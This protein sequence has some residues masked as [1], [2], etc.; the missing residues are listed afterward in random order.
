MTKTIQFK[1][2]QEEFR[3]L[4]ENAAKNKNKYIITLKDAPKNASSAILMSN[5]EYE[6][7]QETLEIMSDKKLMREIRE[8]EKEIAEGK[9]E[10]WED[11]KKELG[12]E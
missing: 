5:D 4:V 3:K 9:V 8:A 1:K 7:L 12:F 6:S 10:D 11:V 2:A